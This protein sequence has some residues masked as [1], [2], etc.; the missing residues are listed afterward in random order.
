MQEGITQTVSLEEHSTRDDAA[1]LSEEEAHAAR[2]RAEQAA[3]REK[4]W[5]ALSSVVAAIFLTTF[6]LIV[7]LLTNSLGILSE[8]AH[9]GLDLV[10]ALVT[11]LAVRLSD[12]PAD[13]QHQFGHGK[14]E[15]L[16]ALFETLLLLVTCVWI[17]YEAI[18][19]LLFKEVQVEASLWAFLIMA[20]SIV[21]DFS[22]SRILYRVARKH[23]SQALEADALHFSTDIWSSSVV[24]VGLGL[25]ALADWLPQYRAWLL[26]ADAVAALVVA[27]IVVWVSL[28]LG[29]RTVD[30]LLDRAPVGLEERIRAAIGQVEHVQECSRLRLRS[31]GPVLFV[32]A[33]VR[34]SPDVSAGMVHEITQQVEAAVRAVH[35]QSDVTVSIEPTEAEDGDLAAHV[36]DLA[37]RVDLSVHDVRVHHMADGHHVDLDL[38]VPGDLSLDEAHR[39]A[40]QFEETLRTRL[41]GVADVETHIEVAPAMPDGVG[42]DVTAQHH[43][44]VGQVRQVVE[45]QEN[46][47]AC[48]DVRVRYVDND[49]YVSLHCTCPASLSMDEAHR[50]SSQVE[51][52]LREALPHVEHFLVHMEPREAEA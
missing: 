27:V 39:L 10:A 41:D 14:V 49:L 18:S 23:N 34:I 28:R 51:G 44:L 4:S 48:H 29:K 47:T 13:E 1:P 9:S 25:V 40:T 32:E 17:F 15:N 37:F 35:P 3:A 50:C 45:A 20:V 42:E 26:R 36:R 6:K 5:A 38:E 24:I 7:G 31:G 21:I 33:T 2:H 46:V 16:S 11:F 12:R 52:R 19:R 22:R 30:A 8:A 43:D